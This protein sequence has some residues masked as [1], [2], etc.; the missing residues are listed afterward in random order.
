MNNVASNIPQPT[1]EINQFTFSIY[2]I[3]SFKSVVA[4]GASVRKRMTAAVNYIDKA[5]GQMR[6]S[7]NPALASIANADGFLD[8]ADKVIGGIKEA[9]VHE[10]DESKNPLQF[11]EFT[12]FMK[13]DEFLE[14]YGS[15]IYQGNLELFLEKLEEIAANAEKFFAERRKELAA[16]GK[17]TQSFN[18]YVPHLYECRGG[19]F[20]DDKFHIILSLATIRQMSPDSSIPAEAVQFM[21]REYIN[22]IKSFRLTDYVRDVKNRDKIKQ[23]IIDS[24]R[25]FNLVDDVKV[26]HL[27]RLFADHTPAALRHLNKGDMTMQKASKIIQ[28][29]SRQLLNDYITSKCMPVMYVNLSDMSDLPVA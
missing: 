10:T 2:G 13:T 27:N 26:Y 9:L 12:R 20:G 7:K 11:V 17:A 22:A 4:D 29:E 23:T 21:C 15:D 25:L 19:I 18:D 16:E 1:T 6:K 8:L 3:G 5:I 28:N 24:D 14:Q